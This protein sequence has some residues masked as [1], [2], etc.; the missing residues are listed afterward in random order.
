MVSADI[1]G[2]VS[3]SWSMRKILTFSLVLFALPAFARNADDWRFRLTPYLWFAGVKGDLSSIPGLPTAR[4][5]VSASDAL[6]DA[7]ESFMLIFEAKRRRHGFFADIFYSD[8]RQ[9]EELV[10]EIGLRLKAT[11]K[12]TMFSAAYQYELYNAQEATVDVF[13]GLRYWDVDTKLVF[14]GGLGVLEGV[15][16]QNAESWVD[17][18]V[19]V[20]ARMRLG[21]SRFF[22]VGFLGGGGGLGS[23]SDHFYDTSVNVGYQ[24]T[25]AISTSLGY[26]IFDVDYD[27]NS[28][29]YDV[30]QEGWGLGLSWVF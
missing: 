4:I 29:V 10:P 13:G 5:D 27:H 3:N 1:T 12:N 6:D 9:K 23:G 16:V 21:A 20:K 11:S 7:E 15:S 2:I 18:L 19:G 14:R 8:V 22:L 26:R 30:K 24:W 28:F 25:D 17:P